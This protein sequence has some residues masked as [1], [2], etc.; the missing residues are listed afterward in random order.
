MAYSAK[1]RKSHVS[2]KGAKE[3]AKELKSMGEG[4]KS[5]LEKSVK[6]G[7]DVA[8]DYAKQNCPVDTGKLKNSLKATVKKVSETRADI[9]VDYDKSL[10]YGTFVELGVKGRQPKPFLRNAIDTN[11]KEINRI[12][13][14]TI[15]KELR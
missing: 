12:I 14:E 1:Q 8:L 7:G 2:V 11:E 15:A 6:A 10:Y 3:L 9:V 13:V 5:V 4:A